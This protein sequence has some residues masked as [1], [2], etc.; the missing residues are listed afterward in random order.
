L[1]SG[2]SKTPLRARVRRAL[3]FTALAVTL[4]AA[5][6]GSL[7]VATA[8]PSGCSDA[9]TS[10]TKLSLAAAR[11]AVACLINQQRAAH[12][13]P[14]LAD[15][16]RLSQ[17]AQSWANR[18]VARD[19]FDHGNF[20]ARFHAAGVNFSVAGEN[21]ATGQRTP[22]QVVR[23]WMASADHCRNILSPAYRE[24]GT[25]VSPHPVKGYASGPATWDDDFALLMH[26]RAP[27][28]NWAP[29]NGCPY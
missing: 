15:S 25:G 2:R 16:T 3:W 21:L 14:G 7:S 12:G 11:A 19:A 10:A 24:L 23:A 28:K 9:S 20:A 22:A 17:S 6:G 27:S 8:T 26:H 1:A 13:L 4:A 18:L 5:L 29:A